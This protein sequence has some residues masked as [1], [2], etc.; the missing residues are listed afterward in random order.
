M[1]FVFFARQDG[2]NE[3]GWMTPADPDE[4]QAI[5]GQWCD[6][7]QRML[8]AAV[9][10]PMFKWA[11][12]A[13]EPMDTWV[14]D[15]KVTLIGDAAHAMTPFLGHGAA[16]GIEDAVV[17]ARALAASDTAAEG[18]ARYEAA[19]HERATFIQ[20]ES[21]ANADRM[22]GQDTD[23]FG[24]GQMKDEESLGLFTYDPRAVAV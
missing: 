20:R 23:L 11:I 5:Y 10:Q 12:N 7:A 15:G 21:N 19:R 2:W 14:L 16:C 1:N 22:Q 8:S 13:R 6:D 9:Q 24:L 17:L 18:L 3:E 4:L